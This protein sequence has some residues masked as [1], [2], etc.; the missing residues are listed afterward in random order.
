MMRMTNS[1]RLA[2][3]PVPCDGLQGRMSRRAIGPARI[4]ICPAFCAGTCCA[5]QLI[6]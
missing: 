4:G 5:E 3:S 2:G 6:S 1:L